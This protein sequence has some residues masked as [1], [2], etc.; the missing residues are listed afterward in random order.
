[1]P[2][3]TWPFGLMAGNWPRPATMAAYA[4]GTHKP[5]K[6]FTRSEGDT[7]VVHAVAW[8]P[9][10]TRLISGSMDNTAHLVGRDAREIAV[11]RP[12]WADHDRRLAPDGVSAAT[13]CDDKIIRLFDRDGK[14]QF[15]SAPLGNE[16]SSLSF[17]AI[18]T[19]CCS[20]IAGLAPCRGG[21]GF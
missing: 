19:N 2:F 11:L 3:T 14:L 15:A 16:I 12:R 9:D 21:L 4:F 5:A 18:R 17:S 6:R 8:S 7:S 10:G 13:G 20:P 1:M